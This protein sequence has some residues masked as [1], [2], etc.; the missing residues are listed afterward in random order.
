MKRGSGTNATWVVIYPHVHIYAYVHFH[1]M[2]CYCSIS[3]YIHVCIYVRTYICRCT[4]SYNSLS[5]QHFHMV[6]TCIQIGTNKHSH[7]YIHTNIYMH[8]HDACIH[9]DTILTPIS[10][11][12]VLTCS[13]K[14]SLSRTTF[15]YSCITTPWIHITQ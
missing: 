1:A 5:L 6:L 3:M 4:N 15:W 7:I 12:S 9:K 13:R 10:A 8:S 2:A 11:C 14:A